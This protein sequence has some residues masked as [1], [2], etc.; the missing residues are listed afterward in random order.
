MDRYN[1][2][3]WNSAFMNKVATLVVKINNYLWRKQYGKN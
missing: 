2:W 1:H 3:L